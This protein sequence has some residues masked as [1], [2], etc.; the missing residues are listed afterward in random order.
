MQPSSFKGEGSKIERDA[1][2]WI[3]SMD[4]Y[5]SAAGT[6][7]ANRS[8]LA[9]FRLTGN[10][11]LWWKQWCKDQGV[12][13]HSQGWDEIKQA[14]KERYLP[15]AHESIK[16]NEFFNLR[17]WDMSLEDYYSKFVTLRKYAPQMTISQ[18]VT[19]FCQG[20]NAP[21]D[22]RLEAMRPISLQDALLRAKPLAKESKKRIRPDYD[23]ED[24]PNRRPRFNPQVQRRGQTQPQSYPRAYAVTPRPGYTCFECNEPGHFRSECPRL[25]SRNTQNSGRGTRG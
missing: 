25:A 15:P 2:I 14:V 12:T 9:R 23:N 13:E 16:M 4:D 1:E 3:E 18:Q 7:P 11:K 19:R 24:Q 8:M 20:L 21:L 22:S 10:A 6:T 17:Q 5:F